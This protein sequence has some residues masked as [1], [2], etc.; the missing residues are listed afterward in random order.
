MSF[1]NDNFF[2]KD[3]RFFVTGHTGFMRKWPC[4]LLIHLGAVVTGYALYPP[5]NPN[6]FSICEI[7][8]DITSITGDIRDYDTLK[9]SFLRA[10]P[11]IV[12]HLAA[13][14]LVLTGYTDPEHTYKTNVIGTINI[15]ECLR[16]FGHTKSFLNI[17]TDKVYMNMEWEWG[18][19]ENDTLDGYDPYSNSKSCSELIIQCYNRSFFHSG[20]TAV[21]TA[22]AGNAIGGGDFSDNRIIPDCARA[23][24]NNEMI[25][26]RNPYST[27]PY[28]H[29]FESV[30][31]Y[32]MIIERQFFDKTLAGCYN[33]GPDDESCISNGKLVDMFCEKWGCGI[34]GKA[35]AK[36]TPH[37][38]DL[39]KLDCSRIKSTFGWRSV[40]N[41]ETALDKTVEWWRVY[42][43]AEDVLS[44]MDHQIIEFLKG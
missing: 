30:A 12:I 13:Q 25:I 44:L 38:A 43:N 36:T 9:E 35:Q 1:I 34:G 26:V 22:R 11:E 41:I 37:E 8:N 6:L 31:A 32:L 4:K 21:S 10:E 19:R 29:V 15:L 2:Y 20:D 7:E 17:T 24:K 40:W 23:A 33:I 42:Y 5:T 28:Q 16:S 18:Y 14:P 39:L 3:K 27:R